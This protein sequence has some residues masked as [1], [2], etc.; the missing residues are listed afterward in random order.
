MSDPSVQPRSDGAPSFDPVPPL[1]LELELPERS[2][3][4]T[5]RLLAEGSTVP[6]IATYSKEATGGLDEVQIRT[7]EERHAYLLDLEKRRQS[8][9]GSIAEQGKLTPE[10]RA[11][12]LACLTKTELED[13]YLPYKPKRR[14]RATAAREKGLE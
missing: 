6:F 12:I 2:V 8:I 7:I 5:V 9:L 13:L 10:L 4:A 3:A 14:T 11:R 1:A